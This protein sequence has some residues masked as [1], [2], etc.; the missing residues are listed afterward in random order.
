MKTGTIKK[1]NAEKGYGFITQEDGSDIFFH[2]SQLVMEGYKTIEEGTEVEYEVVRSDR[3][4]QA[5]NIIRV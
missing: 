5:H 2:Y 4:D 3:G 1:F